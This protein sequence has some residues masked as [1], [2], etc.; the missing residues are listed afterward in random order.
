MDEAIITNFN[1]LVGP[2]DIVFHLGDLG[3]HGHERMKSIIQRL[4]GFRHVLLIGNHDRAGITTYYDMGFSAVLQTATIHI[5]KQT[6]ILNHTP[7][8]TLT[9]FI[10]ISLLYI[11]KMNDKGRTIKQIIQRIKREW[12]TYLKATNNWVLHGHTHLKR[13]VHG[14]NINICV[15]AWNFKPVSSDE[16]LNIINKIENA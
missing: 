15:D 16:I 6:L 1:K 10:R 8:R 12:K 4:N 11:R 2:N 14:K 7:Q 13:K 9:E 3:V 5:G